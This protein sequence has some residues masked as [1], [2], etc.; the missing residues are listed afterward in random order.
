M[1]GM[2]SSTVNNGSAALKR[3]TETKPDLIV[4]DVYMPG[5]SGLEVASELKMQPKPSTS[6]CC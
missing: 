4:L 2:T 3:I 6:L 1:P 5:Y